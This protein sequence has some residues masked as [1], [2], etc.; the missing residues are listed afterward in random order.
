MKAIKWT[1]LILINLV[2]IFFCFWIV[3]LL[4]AY[5]NEF[6]LPDSFIW[7][8][9][10]RLDKMRLLGILERDLILCIEAT[11]ILFII[12][13][14]NRWLFIDLLAIENA[15]TIAKFFFKISLIVMLAIIIIVS[16]LS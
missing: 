11:F 15:K 14:L 13:L 12:Y 4:N 1:V 8:N 7:S 10:E 5:Y 9:G 3:V 16:I 6:L 2:L